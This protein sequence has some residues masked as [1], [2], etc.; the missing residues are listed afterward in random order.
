MT[1]S[2]RW[3]AS[4]RTYEKV[5]IL[6]SNSRKGHPFWGIPKGDFPEE[7]I[8]RLSESRKRYC[9]EHPNRHH[10]T[11]GEI[12][13][14]TDKCPEG[15]WNKHLLKNREAFVKKAK[16][17]H[18][19]LNWYTNGKISLQARKCPEGFRPGRLRVISNEKAKSISEKLKKLNKER[20]S[21]WYNNGTRN[22]RI[23]L[24]DS[25]PKG[26]LKGKLTNRKTK[27]S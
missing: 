19:G 22:F 3:K 15:F 7:L 9:K 25:V 10:Y 5:K 13:V 23:R 1:S 17:S 6:M 16:E 14:F 20:P 21:T 8:S 12:S 24:G 18:K 27:N 11:N 26:L 4:S 2:G